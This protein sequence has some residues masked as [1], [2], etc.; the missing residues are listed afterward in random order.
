MKKDLL[1]HI[2]KMPYGKI[3]ILILAGFIIAAWTIS[4]I[5]LTAGAK[6]N[7]TSASDMN[8]VA[9]GNNQFAWQLYGK[10]SAENK[11]GNLFFSPYSISTALC[12]TYAGAKGNTEKQMADVLHF[13]LPQERLHPAFGSLEKGLNEQGKEG[14][15]D[16]T[17]ANALWPQKGFKFLDL[18]TGLVNK[19]YSAGLNEVDYAGDTEGAR[20]TINKWV[21][22]KTK[23]KIKELIKPGVLDKLTRMVLTNAIYFKGRWQFE[24]DKKDTKDTPFNIT[25]SSQKPVPMMYIKKEFRYSDLQDF[26]ILELGYKGDALSMIIVLP[27]EI[28]GIGK[29]EKSLTA[30]N[31]GIWI[32][33]M[34]RQEVLVYLPRFKFTAE[35]SLGQILAG[36]GMPEAFSANADF[37]GMTGRK[38]LFI[39]AVLHKAFVEVNEEGTEAAAATAVVMRLTAARQETIFRADH[40]FIFLIRDNKINSI[41]FMGRVCDPTK[42]Q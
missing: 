23:D 26:Q 7:N 33:K 37:S 31:L 35:F 42:E 39:S 11:N 41:L 1:F 3:T 9:A 19:N 27:K 40:P 21:E 29:L 5:L 18:F 16:L 13:T 12:M 32:A 34:R 38:D 28:D 2:V 6:E 10:L 36:M 17:V 15:F 22:E 30:E 4:G 25:A 14:V 24:F 20:Q 8:S